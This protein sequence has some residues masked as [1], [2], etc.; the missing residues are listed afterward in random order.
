MFEQI[1]NFQK[2]KIFFW[3]FQIVLLLCLRAVVYTC[4]AKKVIWKTCQSTQEKNGEKTFFFKI[5]P[6]NV[7]RKGLQDIWKGWLRHRYGRRGV[8]IG[9]FYPSKFSIFEKW[10]IS[11]LR[12]LEN[13]SL[14][15]TNAVDLAKTFLGE[16]I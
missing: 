10:I 8:K 1:F 9:S 13:D 5:Q 6:T 3:C 16:H 11:F 15:K 14:D 2:Y 12:K 7:S 4:S